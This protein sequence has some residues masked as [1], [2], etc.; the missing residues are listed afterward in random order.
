MPTF[1][2]A[3]GGR[4]SRA[5]LN[6]ALAVGQ[7]H[8]LVPAGSL[9]AELLRHVEDVRVVLDSG[10]W[11]IDNPE[12]LTL[13]EYVHAILRWRQP[14]GS[15]GNL[16]WAAAY[17]HILDAGQSQR[18]YHELL[19]LLADA[20]AEDAPVVPVAHY[21]GNAI[22]TILDDLDLGH[23]GTRADV[24]GWDGDTFA[25]PCYGIGG[26][27]PVLSPTR[28]RAVFD[29]CDEW[30]TDLLEELDRATQ[31]HSDEEAYEPY[32]INSELLKLHLFGIGRPA[33]V[34]RSPLVMSFDSSGP[35]LQA[36]HGWQKIAPRYDERFGLTA[37]KLQ[38]SRSARVAYWILQ[39]RAGVGLPWLPVADE[40]HI[41]DDPERPSTIQLDLWAA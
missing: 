41:P 34:L 26:M 19:R 29:A 33:F 31:D 20:D 5:D 25:R 4:A 10:A 8:F 12:R 7:R 15:W 37:E 35:M 3:I 2:L 16:D 6:V 14:D 22:S 38:I 28:P 18:D 32:P 39:Y 23:A 27:V 1:Y 11:P 36:K 13:D 30:Y 9:M 21:P 17:D 40:T 24:V